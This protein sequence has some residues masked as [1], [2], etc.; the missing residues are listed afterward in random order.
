MKLFN[1]GDMNEKGVEDAIETTNKE[2]GKDICTLDIYGYIDKGYV[3]RFE[4]ILQTFTKST[5]YKGLIQY[6]KSVEVSKDYYAL[7][8]STCWKG[9]GFQER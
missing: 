6:D 3:A 5:Q 4:E 2:A 1:S 7:L 8:F 9:E